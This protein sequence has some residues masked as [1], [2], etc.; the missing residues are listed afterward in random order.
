MPEILLPSESAALGSNGRDPTSLH[1]PSS[2]SAAEPGSYCAY[3][4]TRERFLAAHV[5]AADFSAPILESR[6]Q[7]LAPNS[8]AGLLIVPFRGISPTSV[9]APIDLIYV[10]HRNVVLAAIESFPLSPLPASGAPVASVLAVPAGTISGAG[11]RP[12]DRLIL[13]APYEIERRLHLLRSIQRS[14]PST[15]PAPPAAVSVPQASPGTAP[16][17]SLPPAAHGPALPSPDVTSLPQQ[18]SAVIPSHRKQPKSLLQ[19]LFNE[20]PPDP[21][22]AQREAF[23]GLV[24]YFFTGGTPAPHRVRD[25]S[26]SGLYVYTGERWYLGTIIRI[27]LTDQRQLERPHSLTVDAKVVRWGNDGVGLHFILVDNRSRRD[28]ELPIDAITAKVGRAHIAQFI[29]LLKLNRA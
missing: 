22:N 3:N 28:S 2:L 19:R 8:G 6:L 7:T 21:R 27:T 26:G 4:L 16:S 25:I 1:A 17:V 29:Q 12:G 9:R 13:C 20:E 10:S 11:T 24:A 15:T 23:P 5:E 18:P 14:D